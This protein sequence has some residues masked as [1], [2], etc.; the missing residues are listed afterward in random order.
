MPM[1]ITDVKMR[2][3]NFNRLNVQVVIAIFEKY[4]KK[5]VPGLPQIRKRYIKQVVDKIKLE[6]KQ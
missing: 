5:I 4:E 2:N 3:A 1:D 6:I